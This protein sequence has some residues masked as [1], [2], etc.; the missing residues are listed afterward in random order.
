MYTCSLTQHSVYRFCK[1]CCCMKNYYGRFFSHKMGIFIQ[2]R[3]VCLFVLSLSENLAS[4]CV[5]WKGSVCICSPT[6]VHIVLQTS[7]H[8]HLYMLSYIHLLTRTC[9]CC[10]TYICWPTPVHAVLHKSVDPHLYM[11]SYRRLLTHTCTCCPTY[12]C[13]PTPVHAVLHTSVDPHLYMLS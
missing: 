5:G 1:V 12:I 13:W 8:P 11:L 9:T 2:E 4:P 7:V 3:F 10:P 6:P